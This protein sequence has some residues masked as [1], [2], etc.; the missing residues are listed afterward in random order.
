MKLVLATRNKDKVQEIS[1]MLALPGLEILGLD[2]FPKVPEVTEDQPTLQGNA[3]KKALAVAQ[4]TNQLALADDTGL[5]VEALGGAPGVY[6]ARYAGEKCSYQDN[7]D[8][9]LEAMKNISPEKRTAIFRC[10]IALAEPSGKVETVEGVCQGMISID[11]QGAH[12]FGYDPVFFVP[13]AGKTFAQMDLSEKNKISHRARALHQIK[14]K[15]ASR[16]TA[17]I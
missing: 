10:V 13:E 15:L 1:A 12:G 14:K 8:K 11:A 16:L 9:L 4:G 7:V 5:E 6:S 2:Q 3:I 17:Q